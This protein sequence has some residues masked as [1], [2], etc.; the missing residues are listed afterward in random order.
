MRDSQIHKLK[1][2]D[3]IIYVTTVIR[4][5]VTI[6]Q[7]IDAFNYI[8]IITTKYKKLDI[9]DQIQYLYNVVDIHRNIIFKMD[10]RRFNA[11][12]TKK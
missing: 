6:E 5:C 4:S 1:L 9:S 10:A 12:Y 3:D 2:N 7:L 11:F 8:R